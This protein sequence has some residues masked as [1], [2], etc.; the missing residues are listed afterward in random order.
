M[1]GSRLF[2]GTSTG[3]SG[4]MLLANLLNSE[5]GVTCLHEGKFRHRE[6]PGEQVLEF[7]TLENLHAYHSRHAAEEIFRRKR[8][9]IEPTGLLG[10]LAYNYAPFVRAIPNVYPEAKLIVMF[11]NGIEFVRSVVTDEDPDPTPV[12]WKASRPTSRVE[13]FIALG[14]LRPAPED[15]LSAEWPTL[16]VVAKNAWLWAETNRLILDGADAWQPSQVLIV[17]FEDLIGDLDGAYGKVRTFLG[18]TSDLTA[19]TRALMRA[20]INRRSKKVLPEWRD[21]TDDQKTEFE[22]FAGS[23]MVQLGYSI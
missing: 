11:R 23:V 21:W 17:R 18:I 8:E 16:S 1:L 14:R 3:R 22:R 6:E 15:P 20:P 7:L 12:G 10:D 13:R 5:P 2:F 4:T 19:V 9:R